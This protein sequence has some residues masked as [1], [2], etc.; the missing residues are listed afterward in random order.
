MV[1]INLQTSGDT[2]YLYVVTTRFDT[3]NATDADSAPSYR[4]YRRENGTAVTNGTMALLDSSNTAGFYSEAVSLAGFVPGEYV[5]YVAATV[6]SVAGAACEGFSV[7]TDDILVRTTIATLASQ[8]SFTLTGG[9][10]D[11]DAINGCVIIIRDSAS[12]DQFAVG[13]V[14]DYTGA[15]KTVTLLTDP[16]VFTMAV[17]DYVTVLADRSL[18]PT[19]DTRTLDVSTGGEAGLDWANVGSPTTTVALSGTTVKTATDVETD[20]ADIQT[21]LPAALGAN[22]NMKADVRDYNGTAGT[23][24]SGRPEVN[25]SHAAGTAWGSGAITAASIAADAITAAKVASDVSAEIADAVWDEA[26]AGHVAAGSFG[27]GVVTNSIANGAITAAAIATDAIDADALAADAGTEIGTAVWATA[28]RTL[29]AATNLTSTGGS[30]PITAGGLVSA[31]VTAIS[32]DTAAA[33]NL[34]AAADGTGYNLGGGS[35]V[36]ASV[37]G[38][39]G[40]VTGNVGGNVTGSVGSLATQ[41]KA[42]VNAEVV[43]TL[44]TDT[45]AELAADPGATPTLV[46]AIMLLYMKVRNLETA[47]SSTATIANNAGTTILSSALSDN[48][49]TFTKAKLA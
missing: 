47:T 27:E 8:T 29:T 12:V 25:T 31:D 24:S 9:P 6:N 41:A 30:V 46:K 38:A 5:I 22:G 14:S 4:I 23:F 39:V 33:D 28:A 1:S 11:N 26:R 45:I 18:K 17:G 32:T 16:A 36:A 2:L 34:E 43:D 10:A 40:S 7:G 48:G 37:T 13:V 42:D 3:G 44:S 20:T 15:S 49:T 21:R 35:V 19:V